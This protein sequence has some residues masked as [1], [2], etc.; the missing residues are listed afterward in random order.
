VGVRGFALCSDW[1]F[2]LEFNATDDVEYG[3]LPTELLRESRLQ[4]SLPQRSWGANGNL[5]NEATVNFLRF[6]TQ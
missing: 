6:A 3:L 5:Q 4:H 2:D 1:I